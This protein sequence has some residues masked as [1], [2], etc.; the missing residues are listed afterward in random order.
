MPDFFGRINV[1]PS[2][3]DITQLIDRAA[4][5]YPDGQG[6]TL[7]KLL[8]DLQTRLSGQRHVDADDL[9]SD[10]DAAITVEEKQNPRRPLDPKF[11]INQERWSGPHALP[12]MEKPELP[13]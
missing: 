10:L 7:M 2:N 5:L 8:C 1:V 12:A 6:T 3:H 9:M 4:R 11:W 13:S